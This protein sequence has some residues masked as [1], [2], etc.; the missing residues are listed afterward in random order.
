MDVKVEP[1]KAP[2]EPLTLELTEAQKVELK[3]II[4]ALEA[5]LYDLWNLWPFTKR[6]VERTLTDPFAWV[7]FAQ[8]PNCAT[9]RVETSEGLLKLTAEDEM[10]RVR[11]MVEVDPQDLTERQRF[12]LADA[13]NRYPDRSGKISERLRAYNTA[14]NVLL[15]GVYKS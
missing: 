11:I 2:T 15:R 5:D 7:R 3:A 4:K 14:R 6:V 8:S 1:A 10:G 9:V 12:D 13:I